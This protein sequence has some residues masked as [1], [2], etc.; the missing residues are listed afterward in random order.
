MI[1]KHLVKE[2]LS[3]AGDLTHLHCTIYR[4]SNKENKLLMENI[5]KLLDLSQDIKYNGVKD[6]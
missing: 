2:L 1:K 3:V 4:L 5:E 6:N